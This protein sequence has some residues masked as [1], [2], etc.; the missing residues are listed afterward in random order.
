MMQTG[1]DSLESVLVS[2]IQKLLP[3]SSKHVRF[4]DAKKA[5]QSADLRPIHKE[6]MLFLLHK[7]SKGKGLDTALQKLK[8]KYK[9]KDKRTVNKLLVRF[10]ELGLN[11]ITLRNS[12]LYRELPLP[13]G[14]VRDRMK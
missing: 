10:D 9:I 5:V 4:R 2:Y 1:Y 13:L 6:Q 7:T 14:M 11:P 8:K 12:S 3:C